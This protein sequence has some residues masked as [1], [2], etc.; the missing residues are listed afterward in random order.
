MWAAFGPA[1]STAASETTLKGG[2][3]VS[4]DEIR[5]KIDAIDS[6]LLPLFEARMDCAREVAAEKR[7]KHLPIF[8]PEREAAILS[9]IADRSPRY[10]NEAKA[11]Y[12]ELM[13]ISRGLQHELMESGEE[14]RKELENAQEPP[15]VSSRVAT[16]GT[17]GS[18][19]YTAAQQIFPGCI[20]SSFS[21]F[22]EIFQAVD[23][24]EAEFGILPVENSSAGSVGEVYDLILQYRFYIVGAETLGIHHCL[25]GR[26]GKHFSKVFS[27]PQALSQCSS[28]LSQMGL[29]PVACSST[30]AGARTA[31]ELEEAAV[32]SESAA[33]EAGLPVLL[34]DI[35]NNSNNCTRF[36]QISRR[37]FIP[38][39]ASKISLCFS[40]PHTTGS[41]NSVLSRFAQAGLNLTKI[42]S[43]P[44]PGSRFEYDFY[45]D[46][47]GNVRQPHTMNLLCSL[48]AEL[49]RF[50]F[51]GNY[52]EQ[53]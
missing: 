32:C 7:K 52:A 47:T 19:S 3:F 41:L 45:L 11:L 51:I 6:Q 53:D 4:L 16:L 27:H 23:R 13:A 21:S 5:A 15:A 37:L 31:A 30:A 33:R 35:Q 12:T 29:E 48:S 38:K 8:N 14:L 40:L 43:R 28:L 10:S 36:I 18:F 49:P 17:P 39:D 20:P 26:P 25:A 46:F 24:G 22:Q 1:D 2:Y 9:H 44:I 34:Q 42:E 50:S